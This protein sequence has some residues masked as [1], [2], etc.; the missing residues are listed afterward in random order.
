[1]LAPKQHLFSKPG[2][3]PVQAHL[4]NDDPGQQAPA[5]QPLQRTLQRGALDK[6]LRRH[7]QQLAAAGRRLKGSETQAHTF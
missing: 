4:V 5:V 7:V 3:L 1:M 2:P 6:L